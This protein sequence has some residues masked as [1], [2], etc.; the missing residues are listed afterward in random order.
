MLSC[1]LIKINGTG[2]FIRVYPCLSVFICGILFLNFSLA[3]KHKC[4]SGDCRNGKG[5]ASYPKGDMYTGDWKN[6]FAEGKGVL[7]YVNGN[8]YIGEWKDGFATG[9]G[10]MRFSNG[11]LYQGDWSGSQADGLGVLYDKSG[12]VIFSGIWKEGKF[13]SKLLP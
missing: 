5:I 9:K 10:M 7:E 1:V 12:N 3:A 11:N 8:V 13:I 2:R 6:G 4:L